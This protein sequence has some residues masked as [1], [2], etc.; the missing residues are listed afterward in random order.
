MMEMDFYAAQK[1]R[2]R[3]DQR[4]HRDFIMEELDKPVSTLD[5]NDSRW[6]DMWITT[7]SDDE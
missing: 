5:D 7:T 6:D 1:K 2:R 4:R 3:A